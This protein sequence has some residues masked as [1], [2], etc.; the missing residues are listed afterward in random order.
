MIKNNEI[1]RVWKG[2]TTK[3]NALAYEEFLEKE[4]FPDVIKK[5]VKGLKKV[6]IA[7]FDLEDETEFFL[8]LHFESIEAVK[9]FAGEDYKT[10]YIP[11]KAKLLLSR[12]EKTA[13][14]YI[15]KKELIL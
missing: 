3:E 9:T 2:W 7:T 12:Y 6:G 10:A 4:V 5:G 14:H 11:E 15:F 1:I 13:R 8:T